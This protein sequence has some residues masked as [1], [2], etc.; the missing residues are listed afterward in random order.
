M[1][2]AA[3]AASSAA[4]AYST[5]VGQKNA[6][7]SSAAAAMLNATQLEENSLRA[8]RRGETDMTSI[9]LRGAGVRSQQRAGYAAGNI[10]LTQGSAQA[11]IASTDVM[12]EIDRN[13]VQA[14]AISEAFGYRTEAVEQMGK[15]AVDRATAR[16]INPTMQAVTSLIGSAAGLSDKW[17][18]GEKTG[19]FKDSRTRWKS[20]GDDAR[21]MFSKKKYLE[22]PSYFSGG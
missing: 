17:Y 15:A 18:Q 1:A 10:D 20:M 22:T 7:R 13:Q 4:G 16:S 19:A 11:A 12:T 8:M 14:N 5:A 21:F 3:G 6:L 2:Q 9:S